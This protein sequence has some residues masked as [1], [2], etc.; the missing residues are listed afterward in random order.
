MQRLGCTAGLQA[1][2]YCT[3]LCSAFCKEQLLI[4][5]A[6]VLAP[7]T[8]PEKMKAFQKSILSHSG[9]RKSR[10]AEEQHASSRPLIAGS[11]GLRALV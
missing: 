1:T 7:L 3:S 9:K 5:L 8:A 2:C 6:G 4:L 11:Q 10:L